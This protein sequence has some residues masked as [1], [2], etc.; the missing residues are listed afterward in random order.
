MADGNDSPAPAAGSG[1][2]KA[3]TGSTAVLIG[4]EITPGVVDFLNQF[5][6]RSLTPHMVD[7]VHASI[8]G[9]IIYFVPA[10]ARRKVID[11]IRNGN[12]NGSTP[13]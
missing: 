9:A 6:P 3:Y 10:D 4:N 5:M 12:G 11:R 13:K 8:V 1:W 7:L 2:G